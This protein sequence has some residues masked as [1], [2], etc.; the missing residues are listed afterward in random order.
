M[1][2]S[3]TTKL[4]SALLFTITS[5]L[6]TPEPMCYKIDGRLIGKNMD[7]YNCVHYTSDYL[8]GI[9]VEDGMFETV[10]NVG[11]IPSVELYTG[12]LMILPGDKCCPPQ[13]FVQ[14]I[15]C[16]PFPEERGSCCRTATEVQVSGLPEPHV[17][18]VHDIV[19]YENHIPAYGMTNITMSL[20]DLNNNNEV[21]IYGG[22]HPNGCCACF[23]YSLEC[24]V[25]Q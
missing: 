18:C 4:V 10:Q 8:N 23:L 16:T 11:G 17:Q 20:D 9:Q 21:E 13:T 24:P 15:T 22:V 2:T 7:D 14:E 1:T 6:G 19:K 3:T 12:D 5:V 25:C